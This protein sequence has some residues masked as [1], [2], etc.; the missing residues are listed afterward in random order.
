VWSS[1]II[2]IDVHFIIAVT[3]SYA[4][5]SEAS[6]IFSLNL[7]ASNVQVRFDD[8]DDDDDDDDE[9]TEVSGGTEQEFGVVIVYFF[10]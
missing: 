3:I 5:T 7:C 2:F 9:A 1:I 8:D 4:L 6:Q 10:F